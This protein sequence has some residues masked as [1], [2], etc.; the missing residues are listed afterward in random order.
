MRVGSAHYVNPV[1]NAKENCRVVITGWPFANNE[2]RELQNK[3]LRS[4][5]NSL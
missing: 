1:K 2:W 4:L 3:N 5:A